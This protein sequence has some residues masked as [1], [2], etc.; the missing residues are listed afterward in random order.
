MLFRSRWDSS[1]DIF[2]FTGSGNSYLLEQVIAPRRGLDARNKRAVYDEVERRASLIQKL[3]ESGRA[4][5]YDLFQ[6]FSQAGREG[7]I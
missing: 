7:L 1:R 2:E 4:N 5:F 3:A 6:V